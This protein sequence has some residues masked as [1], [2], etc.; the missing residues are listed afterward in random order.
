MD[1]R[2]EGGLPG[3]CVCAGLYVCVLIVRPLHGAYPPPFIDQGEGVGYKYATNT[4]EGSVINTCWRPSLLT[5][6]SSVGA[7]LRRGAGRGL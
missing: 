5:P 4:A 7:P 2:E 3:L 1:Q 6:L